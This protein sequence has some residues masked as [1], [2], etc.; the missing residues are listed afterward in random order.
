MSVVAN[1]SDENKPK[2]SKLRGYLALARVSNTPTVATNVLAGA[3][4]AVTLSPS[5]QIFAL[6][7]SMVL[8]YT[9]GMFLNDICDYE[10]DKQERTERPLVTGIISMREAWVATIALFVVAH[11]LLLPLGWQVSLAGVFLTG[12]IILYD[13]WHKK[14]IISPLIMG[15]N[16]LLVYVTAYL[17]FNPMLDTRILVPA[18]LLLLYILSLTFVAKSETSSESFTK[19]WPLG[20]LLVPAIYYAVGTLSTPIWLIVIALFVGWVLYSATFIYDNQKR[21]VG[22]AIWYLIAG[23]A[24]L[25]AMVLASVGSLVGVGIAIGGFLLTLYFQRY[26]KG[27]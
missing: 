19:F 5:W 13:T 24:L 21:S 27:T 16:R 9:A 25:D 18:G 22:R 6:I 11:A 12:F 14:N 26:I 1:H 10:I 23:V 2:Q 3:A 4:L 8:F 7:I 17:A 15:M 20:L